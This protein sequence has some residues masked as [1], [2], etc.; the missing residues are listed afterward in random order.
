MR[1]SIIIGHKHIN[2][3]F[4]CALLKE[5]LTNFRTHIVEDTLPYLLPTVPLKRFVLEAGRTTTAN[6][7]YSCGVFPT[8]S[9]CAGLTSSR[10][11][12]DRPVAGETKTKEF[13]NVTT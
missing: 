6:R 11:D 1:D 9:N 7:P 12:L 13:E 4:L 10:F 8:T 5:P 3:L 2:A